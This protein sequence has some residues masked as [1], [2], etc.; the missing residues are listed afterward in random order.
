M[1]NEELIINGLRVDMSPDTRIVLNFKS[2]LLGDVS[3]ITSSNSQTI[4]LPKTI[5]NRMIF[6]HATTPARNSSFPYQRHPAEYIRN[7]VKIISDAYAV[8]LPN[9]KPTQA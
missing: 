3:K 1:K 6:D 4:Q 7:G 8:M 5:R 2:N 9:P